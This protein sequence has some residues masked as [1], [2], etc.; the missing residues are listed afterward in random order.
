MFA[1]NNTA[2]PSNLA[3]ITAI[4]SAT[5]QISTS[6]TN[7]AYSG[8]HTVYLSCSY[9]TLPLGGSLLTV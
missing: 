2:V 1:N 3:Q 6:T 9:N 7:F 5:N 4:S 8:V